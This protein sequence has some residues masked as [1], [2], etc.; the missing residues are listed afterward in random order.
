MNEAWSISQST[1]SFYEWPGCDIK[2]RY[3]MRTIGFI[4]R[5]RDDKLNFP[6]FCVHEFKFFGWSH[7]Y[8][9]IH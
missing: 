6:S 1:L 2:F 9:K 8:S 3:M 4:L 5:S 7:R